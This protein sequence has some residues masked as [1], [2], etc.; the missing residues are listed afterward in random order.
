MSN[1]KR[2]IKTL[3]EKAQ[4]LSEE[5]DMLITELEESLENMPENMQGGAK[6]EAAQER[7]DRLADWRDQL[8][9][10]AEEDEV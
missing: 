7:I 8:T 9:D 3:Q 4:A 5:F 1:R 2:Q 6:E 10:M